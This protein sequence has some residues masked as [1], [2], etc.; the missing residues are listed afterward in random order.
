MRRHTRQVP[1]EGIPGRRPRQGKGPGADRPEDRKCQES[2]TGVRAD[3]RSWAGGLEVR[4]EDLGLNSMY[5]GKLTRVPS[6]T[7][8]HWNAC[9]MRHGVITQLPHIPGPT[10]V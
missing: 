7:L 9:S 1:G 8:L 6:G 3:G 10:S 5:D 4:G 2:L